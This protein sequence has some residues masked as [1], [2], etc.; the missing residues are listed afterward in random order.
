MAMGDSYGV[1]AGA[2]SQRV[3]NDGSRTQNNRVGC[4][5]GRTQVP[6]TTATGG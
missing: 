3:L 4:S 1:T 5:M 2:I 6:Q